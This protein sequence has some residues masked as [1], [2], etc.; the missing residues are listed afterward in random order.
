LRREVHR[1]ALVSHPPEL[2]YG[3]VN[4]V[5]AYPEFLPWCRASRVLETGPEHMR[6]S[7]ELA[8]GGL[9]KWFTT[10]NALLPGRRIAIELEE[11]PFK[12]LGGT[13]TFE[14]IGAAGCKVSLDMAFEFDSVLLDLTLGPALSEIFGSLLDAF[15]ARAAAQQR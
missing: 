9:A 2:M 5:A 6:A 7:L 12:A 10:R 8:R 4:D 1:S 11:G 15:V 3:L 14:P 13:W